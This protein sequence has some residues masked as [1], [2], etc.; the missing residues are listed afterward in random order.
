MT[1]TKLRISY[2]L[3]LALRNSKP[4]SLRSSTTWSVSLKYDVANMAALTYQNDAVLL[5]AGLHHLGRC[6]WR[7][8]EGVLSGFNTGSDH[9]L[10]CAT[11]Y[12][13]LRLRQLPTNRD[14]KHRQA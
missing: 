14:F 8:D 4:G 11:S 3:K 6:A 10:I 2:A 12:V 1:L 7:T 5:R 9:C 13:I